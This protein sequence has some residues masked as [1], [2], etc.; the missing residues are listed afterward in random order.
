MRYE[1]VLYPTDTDQSVFWEQGR[2]GDPDSYS[3]YHG[4][5]NRHLTLSGA[6]ARLDHGHEHH[7]HDMTIAMMVDVKLF[8]DVT[9]CSPTT[10]I[11]AVNQSPRILHQLHLPTCPNSQPSADLLPD[12]HPIIQHID[13]NAYLTLTTDI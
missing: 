9:V 12:Q 7:G 13:P 3:S 4:A 2:P 11:T 10:H 1:R 8:R 6:I 5:Q